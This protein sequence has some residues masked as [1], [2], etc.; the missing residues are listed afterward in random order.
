MQDERLTRA[1]LVADHADLTFESGSDGTVDG[2]P[3]GRD[4]QVV[5]DSSPLDDNSTGGLQACRPIARQRAE[6]AVEVAIEHEFH[7]RLPASP[8]SSRLR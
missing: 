5:L 4:G 1:E 8:G 7:R 2:T 6:R 3:L